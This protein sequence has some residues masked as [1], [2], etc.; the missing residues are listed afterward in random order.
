MPL[1]TAS[2]RVSDSATIEA[3]T[4]SSYHPR[5]VATALKNFPTGAS[6]YARL[7][8]NR[9]FNETSGMS[10]YPRIDYIN[11]PD[12]S[13]IPSPEGFD[14]ILGTT[15]FSVAGGDTVYLTTAIDLAYEV[16]RVR[17]PACTMSELFVSVTDAPGLG[18]S[19]T[20]HVLKNGSATSLGATISGTS[21]EASIT[22]QTVTFSGGDYF[23]I[24][25]V[26]SAGST[27]T[28]HGYSTKISA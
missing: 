9:L 10:Y 16:V 4:G 27:T 17:L 26:T 12:F 1:G 20:Y 19:F 24:R 7:T 14:V 15:G 25:V 8:P 2:I 13:E 6:F 22:G 11:T 23:A 18:H 28:Y 3:D 5:I 21:T